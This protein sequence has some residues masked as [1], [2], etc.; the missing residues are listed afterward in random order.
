MCSVSGYFSLSAGHCVQALEGMILKVSL[1]VSSAREDFLQLLTGSQA[2]YRPFLTSGLFQHVWGP[3]FLV[4]SYSYSMAFWGLD[5]KPVVF[6]SILPPWPL[7]A[8]LSCHRL[9]LAFNLSAASVTHRLGLHGRDDN[10]WRP[11]EPL[12]ASLLFSVLVPQILAVSVALRQFKQMFHYILSSFPCCTYWRF[13]PKCP[14]QL[15]PEHHC[16]QRKLTLHMRFGLWEACIQIPAVIQGYARQTPSRLC[17]SLL[18]WNVDVI[19]PTADMR[20]R[21]DKQSRVCVWNTRKVLPGT[22]EVFSK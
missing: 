5:Q 1:V 10:L 3:L 13:G 6:I 12:L 11:C 16:F 19:Q 15:Q 17:L 8:P 21:S 4:H 20:A 9:C 2:N 18:I 14:N 22:R 7:S